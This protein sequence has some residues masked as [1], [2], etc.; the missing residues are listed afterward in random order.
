[1]PDRE[2]QEW[3]VEATDA[4]IDTTANDSTGAELEL[5]SAG[6]DLQAAGSTV[7]SKLPRSRKEILKLS[8]QMATD[9]YAPDKGVSPVIF[10]Q[11]SLPHCKP[12][13][14]P[15]VWIRTNGPYQ[16]KVIPNLVQDP[17][18]G[19]I[20]RQY[21]YGTYVRMIIAYF[22][23]VAA[24]TGS[25]TVPL[26]DSLGEFISNLGLARGGSTYDSVRD[27][28]GRLLGTQIRFEMIHKN[29]HGEGEST[30][31]FHFA[32]TYHEFRPRKGSNKAA[33]S[34]W[35][36]EVVLSEPFYNEIVA[37]SIPIDLNVLRHLTT[38]MAMDV[39]LWATHRAPTVNGIARIKWSELSLQFGSDYS[40]LRRFR[41]EVRKSL[42]LIAVAYDGLRFDASR[43]D[44]LILYR[45]PTAI[46]RNEKSIRNMPKRPASE[47]ETPNRD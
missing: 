33:A 26:G 43:D 5:Y 46:A 20:E 18:T 6:S 47:I 27:Q 21:P 22:T 11:V 9:D 41:R 2:Q 12:T 29:E 8:S 19:E 28:L 30:A 34:E 10:S 35:L 45:S 39:Y 14:N 37:R 7:D 42:D 40:D 3:H 32:D 13:G 17:V 1:M 31:F 36:N 44:Y 16:M 24:K 4:D 25:R 15:E 23:T 38:S